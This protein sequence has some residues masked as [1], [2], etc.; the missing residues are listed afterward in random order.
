MIIKAAEKFKV[1]VCSVTDEIAGFVEPLI[2]RCAEWIGHK[3]FGSQ[4]RT[5][6]IAARHAVAADVKFARHA[7]AQRLV[8]FV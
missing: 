4:L 8:L 3:T 2:R 6:E 7:D 1:T 5:L